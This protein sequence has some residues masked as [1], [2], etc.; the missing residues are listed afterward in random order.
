MVR[1]VFS[2]NCIW[3]GNNEGPQI[4]KKEFTS[5]GELLTRACTSWVFLH[6]DLNLSKPNYTQACELGTDFSKHKRTNF[7]GSQIVHNL[8]SANVF[9]WMNVIS[10]HINRFRLKERLQSWLF[11]LH[12]LLYFISHLNPMHVS[13]FSSCYCLMPFLGKWW[14]FQPRTMSRQ[15][16]G[17]ATKQGCSL[18]AKDMETG[19]KPTSFAG[20]RPSFSSLRCKG[21]ISNKSLVFHHLDCETRN[22][23]SLQSNTGMV[24][25]NIWLNQGFCVSIATQLLSKKLKLK[26][27][28]VKEIFSSFVAYWFSADNHL[29]PI[30]I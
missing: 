9:L 6:S 10:M 20:M 3:Q 19:I 13:M 2:L 1:Q 27:P 30:L 21:L 11:A 8:I 26:S 23:Q 25:L 15:S 18:K 5:T 16:L 17:W 7:S 29:V 24:S 12:Y 22:P 4:Q 14:L 28:Q